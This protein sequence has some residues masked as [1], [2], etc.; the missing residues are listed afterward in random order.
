MR[1]AF[2]QL[3]DVAMESDSRGVALQ[4]VGVRELRLPLRLITPTGAE[5]AVIASAELSVDIEASQRGTHMS[6]LVETLYEWTAQPQS[7]AGVRELLQLTQERLGSR[8]A[9][10]CLRFPY[11]V[12]LAAPVTGVSGLLDIE[13]EWDA[14]LA[15]G[16]SCGTTFFEVPALTLCPCSKAISEFGAH[17]Q[18]ALVRL[19]LQTNDR[20]LLLPD[21]YL[22]LI[23]QSVSAL[24]YPV[25]K[26]PDEKFVTE[27]TYETPR[28]VEDVVRELVL[29]LQERKELRWFRAECES[30]ESIHNHNAFARYEEPRPK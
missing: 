28:F 25:L 29:R 3:P 6:R 20:A 8:R 12:S 7:P 16:V 2:E 17:N 26:R 21:D 19:W 15:N 27:K 14:Q 18:R 1:S 22:P 23:E 30:I 13:V 10:L 4:A 11:F 24:V 5:Q 9:H